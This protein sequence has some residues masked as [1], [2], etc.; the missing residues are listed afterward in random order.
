MK[1]KLKVLSS[2]PGKAPESTLG[3]RSTLTKL[4]ASGFLGDSEGSNKGTNF[5]T[6]PHSYSSLPLNVLSIKLLA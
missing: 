6:L 4:R 1:A 5:F 3:L 2:F